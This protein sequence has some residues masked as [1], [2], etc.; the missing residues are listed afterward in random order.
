METASRETMRTAL[1]GCLDR[2]LADRSCTQMEIDIRCAILTS[3]VANS[4]MPEGGCA[5]SSVV[6][7]VPFSVFRTFASSR[8]TA[9]N[10]EGIAAS[11][12]ESASTMAISSSSERCASFAASSSSVAMP[13]ETENA[14]SD[15][16]EPR[17]PAVFM[18]PP[19]VPPLQN[20]ATSNEVRIFSN[21]G[22][23]LPHLLAWQTGFSLSIRRLLLSPILETRTPGRGGKAMRRV[24]V[25][26]THHHSYSGCVFGCLLGNLVQFAKGTSN[27]RTSEAIVHLRKCL[28]PSSRD[29]LSCTGADAAHLHRGFAC[30]NVIRG[31][32]PLLSESQ[33]SPRIDAK[34]GKKSVAIGIAA[35]IY[36]VF[37]VCQRVAS[38]SNALRMSTEYFVER[39]F[40]ALRNWREL[41]GNCPACHSASMDAEKRA[42][43]R[44]LLA[45]RVA[46]KMTRE[47]GVDDYNG[48]RMELEFMRKAMWPHG[49]EV[50]AAT[51]ADLCE[52]IHTDEFRKSSLPE[53][54]ERPRPVDCTLPIPLSQ[55]SELPSRDTGAAME[56]D[57]SSVDGS[58]SVAS[59]YPSTVSSTG[60]PQDGGGAAVEA[61][62]SSLSCV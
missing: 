40:K 30:Y 39:C 13:K 26:G 17:A 43:R 61:L 54:Q 14:R 58:A 23:S 62:A 52:W 41:H 44:G 28:E 48:L 27:L 2:T 37:S 25:G 31:Q 9:L 11:T 56:D 1:S 21:E 5:S 24:R 29:M 57:V 18:P 35:A 53:T 22:D 49:K 3:N 33:A 45:V 46:K 19:P 4:R 8:R 60:E 20:V 10:D 42:L 47:K 55:L 51:Q 32:L 50:S 7:P 16:S 12:T 6:P 34:Y 38:N 59:T 15:P 36:Y